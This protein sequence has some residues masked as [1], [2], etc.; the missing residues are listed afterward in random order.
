[1]WEAHLFLEV[2][3]MQEGSVCGGSMKRAS[4]RWHNMQ[5]GRKVLLSAC[6]GRRCKASMWRGFILLFSI[7]LGPSFFLF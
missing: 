6:G 7:L 4:L 1:M 2:D 5:V 3:L